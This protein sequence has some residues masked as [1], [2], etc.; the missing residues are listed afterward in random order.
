MHGSHSRQAGAAR[1]ERYRGDRFR[2]RSVTSLSLRNCWLMPGIWN[3]ERLLGGGEE[4]RWSGRVPH[5]GLRL[6]G[7]DVQS[8]R[9]L[10]ET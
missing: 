4:G 7:A 5:Y 1:N 6:A 2:S 8:E 9:E 10:S 3:H